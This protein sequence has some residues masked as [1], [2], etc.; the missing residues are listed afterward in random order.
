MPYDQFIREQVAG[1]LMPEASVQ[2]KVATGFLRNSMNTHEG[3]IIAEEYRVSAIA[4]KIDT[5]SS[6][7]LGLTVKCAQC[8]DH[9][10][11]PISQKDY[12]RFFAFFN[13]S[14]EPGLGAGGG[15]NTDPVIAGGALPAGQECLQG[16]LSATHRYARAAPALP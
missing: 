8:H 10:Y 15:G 2:Q 7:F 1:D 14:S 6:A 12:Y 16:R 13:H 4:D 5:V 3:G 9:K 11:D